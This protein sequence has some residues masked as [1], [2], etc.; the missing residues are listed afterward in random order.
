MGLPCLLSLSVEALWITATL[1]SR[2]LVTVARFEFTFD[3]YL[4]L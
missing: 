1:R 4:A 2:P 3:K